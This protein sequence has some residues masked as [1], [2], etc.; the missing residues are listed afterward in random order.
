VR[1]K[2]RRESLGKGI[3]R[4]IKRET[5]SLASLKISRSKFFG[6]ETG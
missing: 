1:I 6:F 5:R 4:I 2:M 3:P